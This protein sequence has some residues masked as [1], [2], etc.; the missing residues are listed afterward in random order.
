MKSIIVGLDGSA[1][2]D[3]AMDMAAESAPAWTPVWSWST[4]SSRP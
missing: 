3:K 2:S 4:W 1:L